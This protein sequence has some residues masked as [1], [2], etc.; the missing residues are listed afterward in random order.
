MKIA[1]WNIQ[2]LGQYGKWTSLWQWI[3]R[4]QLDLVMIQE[5]KKHDHAGMLLDTKDFRLRYNGI[6]DKYSGCLFIIKKDIAFKVLEISYVC[7][8]MYAPNSPM[9]RVKTWSNLLHA[10]H[11]YAN[12]DCTTASSLISS[13]ENSIWTEILEVLNCKDLWGYI[14][15]HTL[16]FTFH[17]RSHK[18]AMSTLVRCY[19][20]HVSTLNATSAMCVDATMLLSDHNP[21]L[22]SLCESDWKSSILDKFCRSPLRLNH[23]WFQTSLF[24]AKVEELIQQV[25]SSKFSACMKWELLVTRM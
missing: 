24:R 17:S 20:S 6:K 3:I 8:N 25:L 10:I 12:M 21:I 2:G 9:E 5:H 7:I 18:R 4:N 23:S 15:G 11:L 14:G 13:Q 22:I 19:Y 16:R 1:S